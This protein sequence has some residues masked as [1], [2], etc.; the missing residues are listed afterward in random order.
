MSLPEPEMA[1]VQRA[2]GARCEAL[3]LAVMRDA[4][5][6]FEQ[7]DPAGMHEVTWG[8]LVDFSGGVS[9][10]LSWIQD[11]QGQPNRIWV[12]EAGW[13]ATVE[14]VVVQ[15][16][17]HLPP[18]CD[19]IGRRL[20]F[21]QIHTYPSNYGLS[22][23]GKTWHQVPWGLEFAFEDRRMLIASACHGHSLD[24]PM[25]NDQIVVAYTPSAVAS[26]IALRRGYVEEWG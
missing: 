24:D 25:C 10:G 23:S 8:A 15:R 18:W 3:A 5:E 1:R 13:F 21:V 9:V 19:F 12:P 14:S 7:C 4:G 26:M 20:S 22:P 16:L 2:V 17:E 11:A 6:A